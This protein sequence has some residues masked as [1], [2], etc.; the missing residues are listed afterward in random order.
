MMIRQLQPEEFEQSVSLSQ[1]AFQY[2]LSPE[3]K[4][5]QRAGFKPER[6][7]GRFNERNE[8]EAKLTL[9]P[10]EVYVQGKPVPMGG[11][12]GVSTWPEK[13]R[14]GHV[15][16]LLTHVLETMRKDG[17]LLSLLH[18]FLVPF[19]RRF[20]WELF[21]DTKKYSLPLAK[22]PAKAAV[23]GSVKRGGR[24]IGVLDGLYRSFAAAYNGTLARDEEWWSR[25]VLDAETND[26][27]YYDASGHPQGYALYK[28]KQKE[29]IID[30]FVFADEEARSG[31]WNF[32]SDHDSMITSAV[33]TMVPAD[34]Q[35]PYMLP[36]PRV[37]QENHPYFM[38]RIVDVAAFVDVFDFVP[39]RSGSIAVAIEDE[40]APWNGG[41]WKLEVNAAGKGSLTT[42]GSPAVAD[43]AANADVLTLSVGTLTAL[44][45]GYK[46]ADELYKAGRLKG[47]ESSVQWLG[48]VVP[49]A[50]PALFDF[51]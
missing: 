38:A 41:L 48:G 6:I 49:A 51:F 12:A 31:L 30:E 14:N 37:T 47:A 22:F 32:F 33:V 4:E 23:P 20:G 45:M 13:R 34:D 10:L 7:W 5:K 15:S 36:D 50:Q 19:Y 42:S 26:A 44:L 29:L 3:D 25:S 2:K 8:L 40:H 18:P 39:G 27:V 16:A 21:C 17:K 28:I 24:D 43:N 46:T 35:L 11:I 1:Y 9:L